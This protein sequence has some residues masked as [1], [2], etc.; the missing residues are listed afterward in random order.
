LTAIRDASYLLDPRDVCDALYHIHFCPCPLPFRQTKTQKK[1]KNNV[2]NG[3][4][5]TPTEFKTLPQNAGIMWN[6]SSGGL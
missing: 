1:K 2:Q 6:S 5:I 4:N 3:V